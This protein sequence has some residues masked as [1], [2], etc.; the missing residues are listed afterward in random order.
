V[1]LRLRFSP[2]R[3]VVEEVVA[4]DSEAALLP[5]IN[6]DSSLNESSKAIELIPYKILI[7]IGRC[8]VVLDG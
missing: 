8:V 4:E 2:D 5:W 1:L 7:N 3:V 6:K